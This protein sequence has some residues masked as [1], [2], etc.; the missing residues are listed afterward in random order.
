MADLQAP[1]RDRSRAPDSA[2]C[3][4]PRAAIKFI[5]SGIQLREIAAISR[6]SENSHGLKGSDHE[7]AKRHRKFRVREA[8][9]ESLIWFGEAA[10]S[11]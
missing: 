2:I 3:S 8:Q 5:L 1:T 11:G 4:L 9:E 10:D 7:G 6:W